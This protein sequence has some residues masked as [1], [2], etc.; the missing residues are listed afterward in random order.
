ET[1][2]PTTHTDPTYEVEDVIHY[3][4]ANMPGAVPITSTLALTNVTLPFVRALA[5][6]GTADA[7]RA[8]PVLARGANVVAGQIVHPAVAEAV[9]IDAVP[10]A[11]ALSK[12]PDSRG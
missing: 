8:D 9:G 3:C 11:D 7:L 6:R 12:L 10:L 2:R 4:V 1:T 5:A